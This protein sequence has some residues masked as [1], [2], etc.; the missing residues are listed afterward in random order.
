M[1]KIKQDMELLFWLNNSKVKS[2][3]KALIYISLAVREWSEQ[4][5]PVGAPTVEED[6]LVTF[7]GKQI[8][9]F[10]FIQNLNP[11]FV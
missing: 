9:T 1:M 11:L 4:R 3:A 7:I 2:G 6:S 8:I 5:L 10:P